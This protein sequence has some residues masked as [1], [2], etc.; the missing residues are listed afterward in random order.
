M[1]Q[2]N[3]SCL[4]CLW[5]FFSLSPAWAIQNFL[6]CIFPVS[7]QM[8][9]QSFANTLFDNRSCLDLT[10]VHLLHTVG[11]HLPAQGS[12]TARSPELQCT[13]GFHPQVAPRQE[14]QRPHW[15]WDSSFVQSQTAWQGHWRVLKGPIKK[16]SWQVFFVLF[17]FLHVCQVNLQPLWHGLS[18]WIRL[19]QCLAH[20]GAK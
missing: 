16:I 3:V 1:N 14:G 2:C 18:S 10:L 6:L 12:V 5:T 15:G 11:S 8:M 4:F 20:N 13:L 19:A 17:C 9:S 7:L